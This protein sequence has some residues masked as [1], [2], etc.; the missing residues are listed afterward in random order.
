MHSR[1]D[2]KDLILG[3]IKSS[4]FSKKAYPLKWYPYFKALRYVAGV[5]YPGLNYDHFDVRCYHSE[6]IMNPMKLV[7]DAHRE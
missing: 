6:Q 7:K 1:L 3:V 2:N 5:R 4:S